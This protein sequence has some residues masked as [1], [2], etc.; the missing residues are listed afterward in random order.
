M[1]LYYDGDITK[2]LSTKQHK[3]LKRKMKSKNEYV[4]SRNCRNV[5]SS[6]SYENI[7]LNSISLHS[8][9]ESSFTISCITITIVIAGE[10]EQ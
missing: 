10:R 6:Y 4:H 2:T 9:N 3:Q 7:P 5:V 8:N 1:Q